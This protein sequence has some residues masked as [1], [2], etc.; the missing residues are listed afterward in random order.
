ATGDCHVLRVLSALSPPS[1]AYTVSGTTRRVQRATGIL[2]TPPAMDETLSVE[3]EPEACP[4]SDLYSI[5]AT[6]I[7]RDVYC[8]GGFSVVNRCAS[9]TLHIYSVDS[10]E[11]REVSTSIK[12]PGP[13]YHHSACAL[14]DILVVAG[15]T[16]PDQ[17]PL[18]DTWLYDTRTGTW[19]QYED[20]PV[21]FDCAGCASVYHPS[22]MALDP[23]GDGQETA[24]KRRSLSEMHVVGKF[25]G[26][27]TLHMTMSLHDGWKVHTLPFECYWSGMVAVTHED[28]DGKGDE[29]R[30]REGTETYDHELWVIGGGPNSEAIQRLSLSTHVW[31]SPLPLPLSLQYSRACTMS[32]GRVLVHGDTGTL[33]LTQ[34]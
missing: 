7:G 1:I 30:E 2:H 23:V 24:D 18:S 8:F 10:G 33:V 34:E 20:A 32:P 21:P 25:Q 3:C 9:N 28:G 22:H 4:C 27:H 17:Q 6:L 26:D 19:C 13:R 15:G 29:G 31:S 5:S 16:G 12:G 14:G 11:W